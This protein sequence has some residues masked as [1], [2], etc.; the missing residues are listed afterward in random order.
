MNPYQ[1][2]VSLLFNEQDEE[3]REKMASNADM[4]KKIEKKKAMDSKIKAMF[5]GPS[6][7]KPR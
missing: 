1:R 6:V 4:K 3:P 5:S 2:L 7:R